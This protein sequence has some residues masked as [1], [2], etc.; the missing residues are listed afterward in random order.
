MLV[1]GVPSLNRKRSLPTTA[2]SVDKWKKL[3][4]ELVV[5]RPVPSAAKEIPVVMVLPK[6][7]FSAISVLSE[8]ETEIEFPNAPG[9]LAKNTPLRDES[10]SS[11]LG[12]EKSGFP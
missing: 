9:N 12:F 11:K 4:C 6:T 1:W 10:C 8:I 2:E 7:G 3:V 5:A